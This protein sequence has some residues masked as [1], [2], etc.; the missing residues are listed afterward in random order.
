[1]QYIYGLSRF[2]KKIK[3]PELCKFNG[4]LCTLD[5]QIVCICKKIECPELRKFNGKFCTLDVCIVWIYKKTELCEYNELQ[6][7]ENATDNCVQ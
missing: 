5:V 1:V 6:N 2:T 4:K 3:Y 7:C